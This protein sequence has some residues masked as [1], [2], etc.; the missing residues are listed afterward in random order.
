[1]LDG[2]QGHVETGSHRRRVHGQRHHQSEEFSQQKLPAFHRFG[3]QG[4]QRSL[5]HLTRNQR[6]AQ[7]HRDENANHGNRT[8]PQADNHIL[9]DADR[10]L[11]HQDRRTHHQ[12]RKENQVVEHPVAHRFPEC[13]RRHRLNVSH[14]PLTSTALTCARSVS[15]RCMKYSSSV[16]LIWVTDK[17]R[18]FAAFSASS[19]PYS[20]ASGN[21]TRYL[22]PVRVAFSSSGKFPAAPESSN[23]ISI[24]CAFMSTSS[25]GAPIPRSFPPT[26]TPTRSH[27]ISASASTCVEKRTVRTS[28]HPAPPPADRAKSLAPAPRAAACPSNTCAVEFSSRCL[29]RPFSTWPERA[30]YGH[31]PSIRETW[32]SSRAPRTR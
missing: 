5:V 16:G 21:C 24:P 7:K 26:I 31:S 19:A 4:V 18:A 2:P 25:P 11:S 29:A 10:D 20:S 28:A 27:S 17:I 23:R 1:M 12:Q 30:P 8:Q 9:L 3:Q 32:R 13:V 22:S 6:N 14:L 15:T